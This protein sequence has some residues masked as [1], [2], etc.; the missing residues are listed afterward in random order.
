MRTKYW[1]VRT[2]WYD[3]KK[4]SNR[5][6]DLELLQKV[7]KISKLE[8]QVPILLQDAFEHKWEK[9]RKIEYIADFVYQEDG[10]IIVEDV[11]S[12]FTAEDPI[13]KIKKKLLLKKYPLMNFKENI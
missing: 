4:E 8:K 13:Y 10:E 5:A 12:K 1:A 9:Y 6:R 11:K 7:W 2:K 3:S